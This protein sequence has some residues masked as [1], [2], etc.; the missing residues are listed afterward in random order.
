VVATT[1]REAVVD[2]GFFALHG[3]A[4][5]GVRLLAAKAKNHFRAAFAARCAAVVECDCPGPAALDLAALPF[6]F[7]RP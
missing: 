1:R 4:L 7:A 2:P 6:R 3:I 5:D